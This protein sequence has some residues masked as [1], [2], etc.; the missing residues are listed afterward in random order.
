M[1]DKKPL[2]AKD[3]V[4]FIDNQ[5]SL[6]GER[7]KDSEDEL[8]VRNPSTVHLQPTPDGQI[9]V[10]LFPLWFSELL[11]TSQREAGTV[12]IFNKSNINYP[13]EPI[14]L[15]DRLVQQYNRAFGL[16]SPQQIITPRSSDKVIK[17]FDD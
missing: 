6:I 17:L 14:E 10:Q 13:S 9:Q 2:E 4:C 11:S 16:I 15:D 8:H 7:V 5:R 3:L 1:S 12:W